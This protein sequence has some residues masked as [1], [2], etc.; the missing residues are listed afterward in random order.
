ML[1]NNSPADWGQGTLLDPRIDWDF[2]LIGVFPLPA[3]PDIVIVDQIYTQYAKL[4]ALL[5]ANDLYGSATKNMAQPLASWALEDRYFDMTEQTY[6][7]TARL[8]GN[9]H[10]RWG[11]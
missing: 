1:M 11:T 5:E 8:T 4:W 10:Q 3:D 6:E 9:S 2:T 7:V